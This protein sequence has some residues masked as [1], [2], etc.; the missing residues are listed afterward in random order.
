MAG[1]ATPATTPAAQGRA[2]GFPMAFSLAGGVF[3]GVLTNLLQGWIPGA[4]NQIANSGAIWSV[5]AFTA[6]A[7]FAGRISP[8]WAAVAGLL[9]ELGLV[10]GYYAYA[11]FGRGGMGAL[12]WPLVWLGMAFVAGPLFGAAGAWWRQGRTWRHRVLSLAALGSLF[13][14]EGLHYAWGL[15]Y[16]PQAWACL[17]LA[18][19]VPLLM[20]RA[21]AERALTLAAA[22]PGSLL[23]YVIVFQTLNGISA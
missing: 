11:E 4:W 1:S 16:A 3:L 12:F 21:L 6:G 14:A 7:L 23:A 13:G 9:A 20:A 22:V 18:L 17:A 2:W 19:L 15:G 10:V 5:V 8:R